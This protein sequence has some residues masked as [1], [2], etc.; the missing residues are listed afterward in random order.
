MTSD[1]IPDQTYILGESSFDFGP[2]EFAQT[3][4]C[5]YL[6]TLTITD[7]PDEPFVVHDPVLRTFTVAETSDPEYL[8]VYNVVIQSSFE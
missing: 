5:G 8:G 1:P 3:P 2:Y 7:L 6:T 4:D